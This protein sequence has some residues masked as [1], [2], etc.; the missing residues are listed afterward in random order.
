MDRPLRQLGGANHLVFYQTQCR[1]DRIDRPNFADQ[2]FRLN[3]YRHD[4]RLQTLSFDES[5]T[6]KIK[7]DQTDLGS[8]DENNL[9]LCR[10]NRDHQQRQDVACG[11]IE[12]RSAENWITVTICHLTEFGLFAAITAGRDQAN[13]G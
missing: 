11:A 4:I 7:Y 1:R 6:I 8:L 3:A 12:R 9:V 5:A 10:R 13:F 2:A